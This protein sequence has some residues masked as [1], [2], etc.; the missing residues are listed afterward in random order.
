MSTITPILSNFPLHYQ[1]TLIEGF[2]S[3]KEQT[4]LILDKFLQKCSP[5][6]K[7]HYTRQVFL[8]NI[9]RNCFGI[10]FGNIYT[11]ITSEN[12]KTLSEFIQ[13]SDSKWISHASAYR[14]DEYIEK[15]L[16]TP[17]IELAETLQDYFYLKI[18][19]NAREKIKAQMQ[20]LRQKITP[21]FDCFFPLI[22]VSEIFPNKTVFERGKLMPFLNTMMYKHINHISS[23]EEVV[24]DIKT[25]EFNNSNLSYPLAGQM[26]FIFRPPKKG[27]FFFFFQ[28]LKPISE[29][30]SQK[31]SN[32]PIQ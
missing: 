25:A 31:F 10:I 16:N 18:G 3:F 29:I 9:L 6:L 28:N 14:Y 8:L 21:P 32:Y 22:S 13:G 12:I 20:G 23:I 4:Q 2:N 27:E 30:M 5:K 15:E 19:E 17:I 24:G 7:K 26:G 11:L 1:N